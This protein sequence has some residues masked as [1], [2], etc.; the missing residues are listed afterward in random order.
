VSN[1][2][3]YGGWREL[4]SALAGGSDISAGAARVMLGAILSD[5]ATDA[6]VASF[7]MAMQIKGATADERTPRPVAAARDGGR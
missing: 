5:E 6:Q 1:L 3:D 4:L 7:I 2:D